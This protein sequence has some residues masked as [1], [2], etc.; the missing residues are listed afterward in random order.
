MLGADALRYF[1]LREIVFGQDGSFSFD[2][3]VQRYNSD[4]ANGLGKSREPNADNDHA[5]FQCGFRIPRAAAHT[6]W[7]R[8][9]RTQRGKT[10]ESENGF[11][12]QQQ[13]SR[14]LEAA[15]ALVAAVDKYIV[16]NE[17][18][19]LGEKKDEASQARLATVLYTQR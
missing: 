3:L 10:I 19:A 9:S 6:A 17:P 16:E 15:W 5:I 14:A 8:R 2:A 1:L 18:W 7:M 13:F 12:D 4:L 11:F